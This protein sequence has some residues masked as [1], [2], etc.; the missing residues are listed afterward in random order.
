MSTSEI[1]KSNPNLFDLAKE[2]KYDEIHSLLGK[3]DEIDSVVEM[4][5]M[6]FTNGW[7]LFQDICSNPKVPL[8]FVLGVL[9]IVG[10]KMSDVSCRDS[11]EHLLKEDPALT[12]RRCVNDKVRIIQV[13]MNE[14]EGEE[15]FDLKAHLLAVAVVNGATKKVVK[16]LLQSGGEDILYRKHTI[17][18]THCHT[19]KQTIN[20]EIMKPEAEA[21]KPESE[22]IRTLEATVLELAL[23]TRQTYEVVKCIL[24]T[25]KDLI[26]SMSKRSLLQGAI[27]EYNQPVAADI[28]HLLLY[29]G[30]QEIVMSRTS[31]NE[32]LLEDMEIFHFLNYKKEFLHEETAD[33]KKGKDVKQNVL[34]FDDMKRIMHLLLDA[35]GKYFVTR[36][37]GSRGSILHFFDYYDHKSFTHVV[38]RIITLGGKHIFEIKNENADNFLHHLVA[39][40]KQVLSKN[41]NS[42]TN[43]NAVVIA[44]NKLGQTPLH[45]ACKMN[46]VDC[47]DALLEAG[48]DDYIKMKDND[49][50]TALHL[51]PVIDA[52][53]SSILEKLLAVGGKHLF[54]IKNKAKELPANQFASNYLDDY[55]KMLDEA[56]S[57]KQKLE[58]IQEHMQERE[59][60]FAVDIKAH[61]KTHNQQKSHYKSL[62]NKFDK[63]KEYIAKL[64]NEKQQDDI[65][66][67][68]ATRK[69]QQLEEENAKLKSVIAQQSASVKYI[70][71]TPSRKRPRNERDCNECDSTRPKSPFRKFTSNV[72]SMF[73][74]QRK[75]ENDSSDHE[76]QEKIGSNRP[77]AQISSLQSEN[78]DL[79]IQLENEKTNHTK[80]LQRLKDARRALK[81]HL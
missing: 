40:N 18:A 16:A 34:G 37:Y 12:E 41:W 74:I 28:V 43:H 36:R 19:T 58:H 29:Y 30:E 62:Q 10:T 22:N 57:W 4:I 79:M 66:F 9:Q 35:H 56:V 65:E 20:V 1:S 2:G 48:D 64:E 47:I 6:K 14:L 11:L 33:A 53:A 45:I 55:E 68:E 78:K 54:S 70:E 5:L 73:Q 71:T 21:K 8:E 75:E 3:Y 80:T 49:G 50:N 63:Q 77:F 15:Y 76:F 42:L 72:T 13:V 25:G 67:S 7:S 24:S 39:S 60:E 26:T 52:S 46:R 31:W 81:N 38:N 32:S 27:L 44:K 51:L 61:E 23:H 69:M 59:K 17:L